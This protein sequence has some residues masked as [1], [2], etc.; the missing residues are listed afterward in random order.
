MCLDELL[1]ILAK[2]KIYEQIFLSCGW[3]IDVTRISQS[4]R[5]NRRDLR[6][7]SNLC[8]WCGGVK[9]QDTSPTTSGTD[10]HKSMARRNGDLHDSGNTENETRS[11]VLAQW[12]VRV[13]SKPSMVLTAPRSSTYRDTSSNIEEFTVDD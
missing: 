9:D 3:V 5:G 12:G 7:G 2:V 1:V 6:G 13:S 8:P 4:S 10:N 11:N